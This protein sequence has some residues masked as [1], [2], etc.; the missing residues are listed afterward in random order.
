[1]SFKITDYVE[2]DSK[3]RGICPSCIKTKGESFRKRNLSVLSNG[4]YKCFANCSIEQIRDALN[5]PKTSGIIPTALARPTKPRYIES[6]T[7]KTN[8]LR[9]RDNPLSS[10]WKW[11]ISR[12]FDAEM[13]EHYQ[14]G[15][16]EVKLDKNYWSISIPI[17]ASEGNFYEKLR[18]SPWLE[19]TPMPWYQ[20]GVPA[21]ALITHQPETPT[22]TWLCEGEWDAMMLGW[23]VRFSE[24]ADQIQVACF[25]CGAGVIPPESELAKLSGTVT[26]WY[27][28]DQPG[29]DG[30][31]KL[32][33]R[34]GDRA[35]IAAVPAPESPS[36]GWD[37]SD[38]LKGGFTLQDFLEAEKT[39]L[40]PKSN[41][42]SN[43]TKTPLSTHG[44]L[45][46]RAPDFVDMLIPDL[47]SYELYVLAA[48]P[49]G[50]KTLMM[51]T[52]ANAVASGTKFLD[53]PTTQGSVL[54]VNLEDSEAKVKE[55]A[56]AMGMERHLPIYWLDKFK[57][58]EFP[59]L[60]EAIDEIPDLR[61]IIIDTLSRAK[62]GK[63]S[64]SSAEMS[65][66]LEPL[67]VAAK[68][69]QIAI[70]LTHHTGKLNVD[71]APS[72]D[73]FDQIR[74]SSAIRATCRGAWIIAPG[75]RSYR[76]VTENGHC[77]EDLNIVLDPC[78]LTWKLIGKWSPKIDGS[79]KDKI[80]ETLNHIGSGTVADISTATD[81]SQKSVG[82][83]LGRLQ[84][85]DLVTKNGGKGRK[86]AVYSR[87]Y[88]NLQQVGA[89]VGAYND[90]TAS[91]TGLLQQ[92][93]N[94]S[95]L[96]IDVS[97]SPG[98]QAPTPPLLRGVVGASE[99][100]H[101]QQ[102]F[103][104]P[105][106]AP[107]SLNQLEQGDPIEILKDGEW[108]SGIYLKPAENSLYTSTTKKM[109]E[110]HWVKFAAGDQFRVADPD[111]RRPENA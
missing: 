58:E 2:V 29:T 40:E 110:S 20:K 33:T 47:L 78:D 109:E 87:S 93:E 56:I 99:Q 22:Q 57:L 12:G 19:S 101:T 68:E 49:R 31:T 17:E 34:L 13:I 65:N 38:A 45:M 102:E 89:S 73:V 105:T 108:R 35:R 42:L 25:T 77:K 53:R 95:S 36:K 98:H 83:V 44:E 103:H 76:L 81:I 27:D 67:Q 85:D 94:I 75:E 32:A 54:I 3:G 7:V 72:I 104:A 1:M 84:A 106:H 71:N 48:P 97:L 88:N 69:R 50:G 74:G 14:L 39:A 52:L 11:L 61:L 79:Q 24:L 66:L 18:V 59:E 55:R 96:S 80:L 91:R 82:T 6:V 41:Q 8:Y 70:V 9:L 92:K 43:S 28:L 62:S 107:T 16:S 90:D 63:I 21:Q 37:V 51:M 100:T 64:E 5:Q 60:L 15:V 23:W 10:A 86:P 111:V 26:I 30:A 46:D 4:S